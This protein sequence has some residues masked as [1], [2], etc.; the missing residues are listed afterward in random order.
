MTHPHLEEILNKLRGQLESMYEERLVSL[1]LFGSQARREATS[2][3][4]IDVLIV[5]NGELDVP[6]EQ[7]KLSE[8]LAALCLE[9]DT[10]IVCVWTEV[11]NW[12]S[13]Q[14]PLFINIRREGVVV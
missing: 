4:D 3:S 2:D 1:V 8:F 14:S 5:M 12:Q 6:K 11:H 9:Y 13:R 10:L 7:K